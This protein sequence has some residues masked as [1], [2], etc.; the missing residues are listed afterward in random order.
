MIQWN[1]QLYRRLEKFQKATPDSSGS[2]G[3]NVQAEAP[4]ATSM[5]KLW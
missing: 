2:S 3:R 5:P 1:K 4:K